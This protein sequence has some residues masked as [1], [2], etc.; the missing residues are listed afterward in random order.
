[1]LLKKPRRECLGINAN[2]TRI[3]D[4]WAEANQTKLLA[5]RFVNSKT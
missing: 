4:N 2:D 3:Y 5:M 1:M